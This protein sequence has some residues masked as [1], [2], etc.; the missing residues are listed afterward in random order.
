MFCLSHYN[1][2]LPL[3]YTQLILLDSFFL[4]LIPAEII[5]HAVLDVIVDD[6]VQ[7][8]IGE[9][10]V[11]CQHPVNFIYYQ[12]LRQGKGRAFEVE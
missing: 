6:E 1:P 5:T 8:F 10:V 7:F 11:T 4:P 3:F 12:Y 2:Y 9:A